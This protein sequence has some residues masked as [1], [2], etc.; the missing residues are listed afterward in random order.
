[1]AIFYVNGV[2][3]D[4]NGVIQNSVD[5]PIHTY[6]AGLPVDNEGNLVT[7]F[8]EPLS[9]DPYVGQVRVAQTGVCLTNDTPPAPTA[10][11]NSFDGAYD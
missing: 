5:A 8:Q 2:K 9:T 7:T 4:E 1:M 6:Q 10:F 3:V 11:S